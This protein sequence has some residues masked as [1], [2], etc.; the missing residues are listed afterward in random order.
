MLIELQH[1]PCVYKNKA[2][3]HFLT[4]VVLILRQQI[5]LKLVTITQNVDKQTVF[6]VKLTQELFIPNI[7]LCN[8]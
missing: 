8:H 6:C 3:H 1:V 2:L 5:E 4:I 7:I